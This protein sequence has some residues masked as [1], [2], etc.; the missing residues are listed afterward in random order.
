[1]RVIKRGWCA[2]AGRCSGERGVRHGEECNQPQW[3]KVE[4][5]VGKAGGRY[6]RP[7]HHFAGNGKGQRKINRRQENV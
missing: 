7:G 4:N 2:A 1:M 3:G 5:G 6:C